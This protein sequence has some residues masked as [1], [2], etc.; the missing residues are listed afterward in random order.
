MK[1]FR[2]LLA[3]C[4]MAVLVSCNRNDKFTIVGTFDIPATFEFGDTVIERGPIEGT[5][6][7]YDVNENLIDSASVENETFQ[8]AGVC[9][10]K[11]PYFA[12]VACDFGAGMIVIE[13]GVIDV[14]ISQTLTATGTPLNDEIADVNAMLENLSNEMYEELMPMM[15]Q[16]G[17][18]TENREAMMMP[19]FNRY[20]EMAGQKIDSIYQANTDNLVGVF[21]ANMQTADVQTAE[22][23]EEA[24]AG[25]SEYVRNSELLQMR[26][27]YL[28]MYSGLD[29]GDDDYPEFLDAAE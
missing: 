17:D 3:L 29:M 21:V 20:M 5:V 14:V 10:A 6:Y 7:L 23:F 12:F 27:E 24:I 8:L 13:P 9:D 4:M 11:K 1:K 28:K 15:E 25:Y 22:E 16:A 2:I 19:V 26:M 18:D